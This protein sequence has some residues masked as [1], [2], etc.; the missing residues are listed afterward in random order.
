MPLFWDFPRVKAFGPILINPSA[1]PN[2]DLSGCHVAI[3]WLVRWRTSKGSASRSEPWSVTSLPP[4]PSLRR[5]KLRGSGEQGNALVRTLSRS[6][7]DVRNFYLLTH[8]RTQSDD[9][10]ARSSAFLTTPSLHGWRP[11]RPRKRGNA[12]QV[13]APSF[14]PLPRSRRS[15]HY[16]SNLEQG[17]H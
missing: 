9:A 16:E 17:S 12:P 10:R 5:D 13:A 1:S 11:H 14:S 8:R 2:I 3:T 6:V 15:R 7:L 4:P